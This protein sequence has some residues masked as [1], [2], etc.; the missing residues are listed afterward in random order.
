MKARE[1]RWRVWLGGDNSHTL[2]RCHSSAEAAERGLKK[3]F[4]DFK[5]TL[6]DRLTRV[7][8]VTSD[9]G[10]E[11]HAYRYEVRVDVKLVIKETTT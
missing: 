10:E 7:V 8:C 1:T 2:V 3:V 9:D 5:L 4:G 11:T 6:P